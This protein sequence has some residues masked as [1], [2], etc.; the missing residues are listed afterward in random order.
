MEVDCDIWTSQS[1]MIVLIDTHV[2]GQIY[3]TTVTSNQV[4]TIR[5]L[6]LLTPDRKMSVPSVIKLRQRSA[7]NGSGLFAPETT[8]SRSQR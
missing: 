8:S 6:R 1:T 7:S 2:N 4:Y 5:N 3:H